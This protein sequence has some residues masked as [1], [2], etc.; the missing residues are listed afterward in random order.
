V[1]VA[2]ERGGSCGEKKGWNMGVEVSCEDAFLES[3]TGCWPRGMS[4]CELAGSI[5]LIRAAQEWPWPTITRTAQNAPSHVGRPALSN[6]R[7]LVHHQAG[8]PS[9]Q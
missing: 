3:K 9:N 4:V 8:P 6:P 7:R 1:K 5:P 2:G